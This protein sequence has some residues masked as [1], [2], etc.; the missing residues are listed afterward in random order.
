MSSI[1]RLPRHRTP[2]AFACVTSAIGAFHR[3]ATGSSCTAVRAAHTA[4]G[5]PHATF[6]GCTTI[7]YWTDVEGNWDYF[8]KLINQSR[9]V[10]WSDASTH[11]TTTKLNNQSRAA[12]WSD[13]RANKTTATTTDFDSVAS[14]AQDGGELA[15]QLRNGHGFVYGGDCFDKGCGDIRISRLL[16]QLKRDYPDRVRCVLLE[17]Y[18]PCLFC[19]HTL[20]ISPTLLCS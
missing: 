10:H 7:G 15:L 12:Q 20:V 16:V 18:P 14:A 4:S 6:A 8:A 2:A 19:L 11:K 9:A 13:A 1:R 3:R 5:V 17:P